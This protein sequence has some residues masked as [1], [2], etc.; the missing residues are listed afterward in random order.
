MDPHQIVH[1]VY[2]PIQLE[3]DNHS[4]RMGLEVAEGGQNMEEPGKIL[5]LGG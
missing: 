3:G 1:R 5:N 4:Y 2:W